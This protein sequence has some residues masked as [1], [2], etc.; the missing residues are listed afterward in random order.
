MASETGELREARRRAQ[1]GAELLDKRKPGWVDRVNVATLNVQHPLDCVL[2]Q[3]YRGFGI[4][5][6]RLDL[7]DSEI[8]Q[9]GFS[10]GY[11][12]VPTGGND[13]YVGFVVLTRAWSDLVKARQA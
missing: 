6:E 11:V 13:V 3:V 4:G 2:G 10:A 8:V 5:V 9:H 7:T 1:L 12:D